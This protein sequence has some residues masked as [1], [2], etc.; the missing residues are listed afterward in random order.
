ME[1]FA[2]TKPL[3]QSRSGRQSPALPRTSVRPWNRKAAAT[4]TPWAK[5][6]GQNHPKD[7]RQ[8]GVF[9]EIGRAR[10]ASDAVL[11]FNALTL[12]TCSTGTLATSSPESILI[13][14]IG[15]RIWE[16]GPTPSCPRALQKL[17]DSRRSHKG[18]P[19]A[20]KYPNTAIRPL[21]PEYL[22]AHTLPLF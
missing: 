4:P 14:S 10:R 3:S 1:C 13:G 18:F 15:C 22:E 20:S 19:A 6:T 12:L 16:N 5:P 21:G 8:G 7:C 9:V 11:C 2:K 17:S